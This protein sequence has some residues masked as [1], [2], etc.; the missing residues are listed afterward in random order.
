[1]YL[2]YLIKICAQNSVY[3][4]IELCSFL[5]SV[6]IIN[7]LSRLNVGIT[8]LCIYSLLPYNNAQEPPEFK[9]FVIR[10]D[11]GGNNDLSIKSPPPPPLVLWSI[12]VQPSTRR[13]LGR[14]FSILP[15][16]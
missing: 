7:Q 12:S 9:G 6:I 4:N 5:F 8:Y 10:A 3:I 1:M 13:E 16:R 14:V 2:F 15:E 11:S